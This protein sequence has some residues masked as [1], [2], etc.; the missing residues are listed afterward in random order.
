MRRGVSVRLVLPFATVLAATSHG[1]A[2]GAETPERGSAA[3]APG[4][5]A[6]TLRP[7][8]R[9][10]PAATAVREAERSAAL[11]ADTAARGHGGHH[12]GYR[13]VDAGRDDV[14][15]DSGPLPE[16]LQTPTRPQS[17]ESDAH[18]AHTGAAPP[19][20]EQPP[21]PAGSA[22]EHDHG[23]SRAAPG[24]APAAPQ[25]PHAMHAKPSPRPTPTPRP[26]PRQDNR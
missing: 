16:G 2:R 7:D 4:Q 3:S 15:P 12:A 18:G 21:E 13:Q 26:R 17:A 9:D 22:P 6:A 24:S 11:A 19:A 8:P 10:A 14:V 5:P 23:Q 20:G 1:G 25:D